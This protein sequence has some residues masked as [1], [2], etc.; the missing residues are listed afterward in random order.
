VRRPSG[1]AAGG[2]AMA[3]THLLH[4]E[5]P[6]ALAGLGFDLA[7]ARQVVRASVEAR[8]TISQPDLAAVGA[9]QPRG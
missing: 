6:E 4:S 3:A 1:L 8:F 7:P 2:V 5:R 9:E